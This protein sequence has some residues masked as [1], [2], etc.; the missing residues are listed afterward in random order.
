MIQRVLEQQRAIS[1]ILSRDRK[2]RHL[3]PSWQDL[4]VLESI[5]QALQEFIDALS[6][7]RYLSVS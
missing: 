1:D 6:G 5:N 3:V 4:D 2:S 7:E